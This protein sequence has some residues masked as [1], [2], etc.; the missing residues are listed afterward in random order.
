ME[1]IESQLID[2]MDELL[3][4]TRK[5]VGDN[6]LAA[7]TLQNSLV[8]ALRAAPTLRDEGKVFPWFYR[9]L[10]NTITDLY[11]GQQRERKYLKQYALENEGVVPP[12]ER[13]VI[14]NCFLQLL[15]VI[16]PAYAEVIQALDLDE[17][18]PAAVAARLGITRDN[19][20]MR[21]HRARKQLR[22]RLEESCRACAVHGCLDC[23]CKSQKSHQRA[24]EK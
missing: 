4:Y 16:R 19:L 8:K 14:C 6:D 2:S 18:E 22:V 20:K 12:E 24:D 3:A 1:A 10:D 11:R 15:P 21:H 17:E 5:R 9:I 7:D 23:S 13:S